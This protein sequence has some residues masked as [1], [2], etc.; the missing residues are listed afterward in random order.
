MEMHNITVY[1]KNKGEG[2]SYDFIMDGIKPRLVITELD[3][4][5]MEA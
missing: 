2:V 3:E 5:D 4:S 1:D